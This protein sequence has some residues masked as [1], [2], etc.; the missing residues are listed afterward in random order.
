MALRW[1]FSPFPQPFGAAS[2]DHL[3][4]S[5]ISKQNIYVATPFSSISGLPHVLVINGSGTQS[6]VPAGAGLLQYILWREEPHFRLAFAMGKI[7]G[8]PG[9][10][11][12]MLAH[13]AT[14]K[15][16]C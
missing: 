3:M 7:R 6:T 10:R 1:A 8:T 15:F 12:H 4:S 2:A 13:L 11:S 14:T 5:R 16:F 9:M